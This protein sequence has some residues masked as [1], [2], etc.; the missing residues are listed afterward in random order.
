MSLWAVVS[1][2]GPLLDCFYLQP[3]LPH[4]FKWFQL[5]LQH[6]SLY[7]WITQ[8]W[9][10]HAFFFFFSK[11]TL[12]YTFG[13]LQYELWVLK[14]SGVAVCLG[15]A[16][17]RLPSKGRLEETV[18]APVVPCGF[19]VVG[20]APAHTAAVWLS[21]W[22]AGITGRPFTPA[23]TSV[24]SPSPFHARSLWAFC[25]IIPFS[26]V[27]ILCPAPCGS[28]VRLLS[29]TRSSFPS[30][31]E[32]LCV[33]APPSLFWHLIFS[34]VRL[35][36]FLLASQLTQKHKHKQQQLG[37]IIVLLRNSIAFSVK[38]E[39]VNNELPITTKSPQ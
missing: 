3:A 8:A 26:V 12:K 1:P 37:A 22:A 19:C 7:N 34:G 32:S 14:G 4:C 9:A 2:R 25:P 16:G 11:C 5:C 18:A 27:Y 39:V 29:A 38:D 17:V 20:L 33:P 6:D 28:R 23:Q 21:V 13:S 24:C 35:R 36:P 10:L 15:W 30:V 31:F